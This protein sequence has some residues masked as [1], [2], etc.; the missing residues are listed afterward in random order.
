LTH[1]IDEDV[2]DLFKAWYERDLP[3]LYR[4]VW[5]RVRDRVLA[6]ELT[7]ATCERVLEIL[8]RYDPARGGFDAWM[9]GIAHNE[10]RSAQR[11]WGRRP[12]LLSLDALPW[13]RGGER[14]VEQQVA[15]REAFD[16]LIQGIAALP[17]PDQAVVALRYGAGLSNPEIAQITNLT[18]NHVAVRL[19]RALKKLRTV[20]AAQQAG[21]EE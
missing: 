1:S 9:F 10:V 13:N 20:L 15:R 17:E 7:A 11:S 2:I 14:P 18:P 8:D 21:A 5:Y 6:E 19:H 4:Y 16:T 3:R 12:A